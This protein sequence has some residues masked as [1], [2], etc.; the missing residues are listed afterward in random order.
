MH[1]PLLFPVHVC[2]CVCHRKCVCLH[3]HCKYPCVGVCV[4]ARGDERRGV[5]FISE[6]FCYRHGNYGSFLITMLY[7]HL[8]MMMHTY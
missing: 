6:C 4:F 3:V 1:V 8:A 7:N 5:K 2:L